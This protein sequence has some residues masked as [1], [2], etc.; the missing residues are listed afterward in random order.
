ML[1]VDI[2]GLEGSGPMV[3]VVE[4]RQG[5]LVGGTFTL[6]AKGR[7]TEALPANVTAGGL[8]AALLALPGMDSVN[9]SKT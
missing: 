6:S 1:G 5:G 8:Q 2:S 4:F 9:V 3:D 7:T